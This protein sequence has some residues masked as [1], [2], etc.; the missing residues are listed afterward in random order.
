[1][2]VNAPS[3]CGLPAGTN[4][5]GEG[6]AAL[7]MDFQEQGGQPKKPVGLISFPSV[8]SLKDKEA[9]GS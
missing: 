4:N 3:A 8:T 6:L 5:R 1:M 7:L 9:V 2:L